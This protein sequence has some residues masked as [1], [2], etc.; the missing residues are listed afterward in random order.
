MCVGVWRGSGDGGRSCGGC[1]AWPVVMGGEEDGGDKRG[2]TRGVDVPF[3]QAEAY[4]HTASPRHTHTW[5]WW[6]W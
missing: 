4:N 2:V 6:W 1:A 5:A 3:C